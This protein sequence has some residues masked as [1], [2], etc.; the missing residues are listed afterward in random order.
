M[1]LEMIKVDEQLSPEV[2]AF[3]DEHFAG[4]DP[5]AVIRDAIES[6][7]LFEAGMGDIDRFRKEYND[8]GWVGKKWNQRE[9][10]E[11]TNEAVLKLCKMS[12]AQ[13]KMQLLVLIV[14]A[15]LGQQQTILSNQ[16]LQIKEQTERIS[17]QQGQIE[18]HQGEL[19]VQNKKLI[20]QQGRLEIQAQRLQED[21]V[22]LIEASEALRALRSIGQEHDEEI[23]KQNKALSELESFYVRLRQTLKD[24]DDAESL[25]DRRIDKNATGIAENRSA[26]EKIEVLG[27]KLDDLVSKNFKDDKVRDEELARQRE[28]DDKHDAELERQRAKD[29]EHDTELKRQRN[30]D[31]EHDRLIKELTERIEKLESKKFFFW[32]KALIFINTLLAVLAFAVAMTR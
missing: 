8:M 18:G 23:V 11:N 28:K 5:Q 6:Y 24:M 20:E 17:Y 3:I 26:I 30:R 2:T 16:Q 9:L 32:L 15:K 29:D 22:R 27:R 7:K 1:S 25:Q 10:A 21:N 31:E 4:K 13:A 14:T 19:E 12:D